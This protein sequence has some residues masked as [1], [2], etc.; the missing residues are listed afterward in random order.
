MPSPFPGMNPYLERPER[1]VDFH[2]TYLIALRAALAPLVA[3]AYFTSVEHRISVQDDGDL[4]DDGLRFVADAT[5]ASKRPGRPAAAA[6][7][8]LAAPV[9]VRLPEYV[10]KRRTP[11]L[12]VYDRDRSRVVTV[13]ELLSPSNKWAGNDREVFLAKRKRLLAA[14]VN[15]V[16]LDLLRAGPRLPMHDLPA[17]DY[18][19]LV[20]RPRNRPRADVWAVR[21]QD[22]LPT[23]PVP[24]RRRTPEPAL[25]LKAVL[26]VA[27]D[28]AGYV[29]HIYRH[30]PEPPLTP[31]QAAWAAGFRP[32]A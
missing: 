3:P 29:H 27:Y 9:T 7:A 13:I 32:P 25:D 24:L 6:T 20:S 23:I 10:R 26:D 28:G 8:T 2:Q 11:Y 15:Y 19:A 18:Y 21:L 31:E 17:C 14:G 4:D 22:Q 30:P 12:A 1:W 5:V 16:E